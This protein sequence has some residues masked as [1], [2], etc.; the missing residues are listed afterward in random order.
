MLN[1]KK[2]MVTTLFLST[3]F[4]TNVKADVRVGEVYETKKLSELNEV[5]MY[6][7]DEEIDEYAKAKLDAMEDYKV[8]MPKTTSKYEVAL[9]YSDGSFTFLDTADNLEEAKEKIANMQLPQSE[10]SIIPSVISQ[11]GQ[12]VYATNS[13][14]RVWKHVNNAPFQEVILI[15]SNTEDIGKEYREHTYVNHNYVDDVPIIEDRG[16]ATKIQVGGYKGWINTDYTNGNYD[17]VVVPINQITNPSHYYVEDGYLYHY[18][19]V[20][21]TDIND[22]GTHL[23]IGPAIPYLKEEINYY[24]YDGIYFYEGNTIEEGL[25][26]LINDLKGNVTTNAVNKDNPYYNY[27]NYLPFRTRTNYSA[28][29]LNH[30]IDNNTKDISKL[31]GMGEYLIECQNK[32]GVNALLMLGVA[33]NE[34]ALGESEKAQE[35]NNLFGI[36]AYDFS[37]GGGEVFNTVEDSIREFAKNYISKRYTNPNDYRYF[38]GYLG[39]KALGVNVKYAS[40]P[41]WGEKAAKHSFSIERYLASGNLDNLR[42]YNGYKLAMYIGENKVTG[43]D[44]IL[45][46]NIN[47]TINEYVNYIGKVVALVYDETNLDEKYEIFPE[48]NNPINSKEMTNYDGIYNWN[49]RGYINTSNLKF[50]NNTKDSFIPG[51][52]KEDINK[53]DTVDIQDLSQI[54]LSY[55]SLQGSNLFLARYDINLDGIIDIFDMIFISKI[56]Q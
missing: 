39:N 15:Y 36:Q 9:A 19:T 18:I 43:K 10:E 56:I 17:L 44:G 50:I 54:A 4:C 31:R 29:E 26:K 53:D 16:T 47:S 40:D 48:V 25:N 55:N 49:L 1:I 7:T 12:V 45:L 52:K 6:S 24:S 2:I 20:D 14:G 27:Y 32:Y 23:K 46:Y 42:D 33:M 41:F 8:I 34:S 5:S 37:P 22:G 51:Y 35:M 13:M 11:D 3:I 21:M 28:D 30:F 38:G